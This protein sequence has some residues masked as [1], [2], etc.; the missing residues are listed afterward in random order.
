MDTA[1]LQATI[2]HLAGSKSEGRPPRMAD[3][4]S[5]Y[6]AAPDTPAT[7]T[8][9]DIVRSLRSICEKIDA[10]DDPRRAWAIVEDIEL[11]VPKDRLEEMKH[12]QRAVADNIVRHSL[13]YIN[14]KSS[15]GR[16]AT[17]TLVAIGE[18]CFLATTAHS[19]PSPPHGKLAFAGREQIP[20]SEIPEILSSGKRDDEQCDVAY[21]ELDPTYPVKRLDKHPIPLSRL[22][23][24]GLGNNNRW[25]F[26]AGY[27]S[28]VV[29]HD[30]DLR[31][32]RL[33]TW[34]NLTLQANEWSALPQGHREPSADHDV[35]IPYPQT[36]PFLS[37]GSQKPDKLPKPYGMSGGGYWQRTQES[38]K[39]WSAESYGMIAIQSRW[40]G[41]G[42]YLQGTQILHWLRLIWDEIP[43]ARPYL[44]AQFPGLLI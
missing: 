23:P 12:V 19:V 22:H 2:V 42:R 28:E 16:I 14:T 32:F 38:E 39:I 31:I 7:S 34:G 40:W 36:E 15:E 24:I 41:L 10:E 35:F 18:R 33:H 13:A 30:R 29:K 26:V 43:Y 21:L 6:V 27:P 20:F 1:T 37:I 4:L 44:K 5:K 3:R 25:T 11:I 9:P 17:G 8:Q